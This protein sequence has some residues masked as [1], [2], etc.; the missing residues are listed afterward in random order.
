M[1]VNWHLVHKKDATDCMTIDPVM[2][3]VCIDT[4]RCVDCL[5]SGCQE[6][7]G[8]VLVHIA[9]DSLHSVAGKQTDRTPHSVS[10]AGGFILDKNPMTHF[11]QF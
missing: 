10:N 5:A 1:P 3:D 4:S 9:A 11:Q 7:F 8:D 6:I 2:V